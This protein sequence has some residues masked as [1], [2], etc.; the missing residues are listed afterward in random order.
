MSICCFES[1]RTIPIDGLYVLTRDSLPTFH[2]VSKELV[3][4]SLPQACR[5][6]GHTPWG[7]QGIDVYVGSAQESADGRYYLLRSQRME[8]FLF[9]ISKE[10]FEKYLPISAAKINRSG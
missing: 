5:L 7:Q 6:S 10:D 3:E 4:S 2:A 8:H 9:S 1:T